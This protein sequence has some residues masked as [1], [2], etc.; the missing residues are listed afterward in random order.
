VKRLNAVG[1]GISTAVAAG[2]LLV[3]GGRIALVLS[4]PSAQARPTLSNE[5]PPESLQVTPQIAQDFTPSSAAERKPKGLRPMIGLSRVKE[6]LPDSV[7]S[8][9]WADSVLKVGM[10]VTACAVERKADPKKKP[11]GFRVTVSR[12]ATKIF[13]AGRKKKVDIALHEPAKTIYTT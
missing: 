13:F 6:R 3:L 11:G 4:S 12:I 8:R 10:P 7:Q 2:A 1:F 9:R 5:K